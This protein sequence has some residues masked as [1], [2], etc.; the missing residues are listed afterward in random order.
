MSPR[1]LGVVSTKPAYTMNNDINGQEIALRGRVPC[2][3]VGKV[4]KGDVL[5]T[6]DVPGHAEVAEDPAA[7]PAASIV[8]KALYGKDD[9]GKGKVEIVV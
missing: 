3:V 6:S 7:V 9:Q 2:K 5:V 8:G 1:L 4:A